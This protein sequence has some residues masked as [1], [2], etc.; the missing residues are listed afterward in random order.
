MTPQQALVELENY[1]I[2]SLFGKP[3]TKITP[4]HF[5]IIKEALKNGGK[6]ND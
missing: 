4:E 5:K 2:E 1:Y 6:D 3:F